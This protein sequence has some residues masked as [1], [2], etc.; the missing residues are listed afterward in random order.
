MVAEGSGKCGMPGSVW[1][2]YCQHTCGGVCE[3][4][5]RPTGD[6]GASD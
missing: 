4:G 3:I 2:V 5:A 1:L 6:A